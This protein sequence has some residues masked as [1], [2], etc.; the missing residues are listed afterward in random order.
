M[1]D[2]PKKSDTYLLDSKK[3]WL[4]CPKCR[5]FP[6][7]TLKLDNESKEVCIFL[8]CPCSNYREEQ[9]TIKDYISQITH[10]QK[11]KMPCTANP[12]H[13]GYL[14][15]NYCFQCEQFLC[16]L[17]KTNHATL[18]PTHTLSDEGIKIDM[19]CERH[20]VDNEI[21]SHCLECNRNLCTNCLKEHNIHHDIYNLRTF[22]PRNLSDKYYEDF[23]L[24]HVTFFK[25]I[26]EAKK[27]LDEKIA[28]VE[29]KNDE[30]KAAIENMNCI[31]K[32]NNEMNQDLIKLISLMFENYYNTIENSPNFNIIFQLKILTRFNSNLKAFKYDE[33][34]QLLENINNFINYL[35][36][37][38]II[39]TI[40]TP[41]EIKEITKIPKLNNTRVLVPLG[42]Y[43]LASGN[44]ESDIQIID[45]TSKKVTK[46]IVGHFFSVTSMC[47]IDGKYLVSGGSD[48]AINIYEPSLFADDDESNDDPKENCYRG[49]L[50]GHDDTVSK[51]I[52]FKDGKVA[53]CGY[54]KR[55][56]V[57][58]KCVSNEA[59]EDFPVVEMTEEEKERSTKERNETF[60]TN[61]NN[62]NKDEEIKTKEKT[63]DKDK[64]K[65]KEKEQKEDEQKEKEVNENVEKPKEELFYINLEKLATFELPDKVF[66]ICELKDGTLIACCLDKTLK[67]Y[68]VENL[69]NPQPIKEIKLDYTPLH[70]ASLID[71][72]IVVAF[73]QN[74]DFGIKIYKYDENK[75][76]T[77][78]KEFV[79]HKKLITCLYVLED[80]KIVTTS[81]DG[82][83]VFY[84]PFGFNV[85]CKIEET[86]K[87]NFTSVVQLED[88]SVVISSGKGFIYVLQ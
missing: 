80:G 47:F 45:L 62:S 63:K 33:N 41:L 35:S 13:S 16:S 21:I 20:L 48:T 5:N 57:F 31:Y 26:N 81:M 84:N 10:K 39:K 49:F 88:R 59:K 87:K 77:L 29:E 27:I 9:Y 52:Q 71:G 58:G 74:P 22:F 76:I 78:E 37:I 23:K 11:Y 68:D 12:A 30:L 46:H 42:G 4:I 79:E 67:I 85:V 60:N 6:L 72:R 82:T 14:S 2:L 51:I 36:K 53:T 19:V 8:K 25:Y 69:S 43:K 34:V 44:M 73:K 32:K 61:T 83:A 3:L 38:Y 56:N 65:S 86:K 7:L 18:S 55:I 50:L 64:E 28:E 40:D 15:V 1:S 75:E 66:D 70:V 54:D 17:C 24:I